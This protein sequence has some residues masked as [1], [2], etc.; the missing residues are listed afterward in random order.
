M[1]LT[2]RG[3]LVLLVSQTESDA[4]ELL[5]KVQLIFDHLPEFLKPDAWNSLRCLKFPELH[6]EIVALP[7][8]RGAG[9]GRTAHHAPSLTPSARRSKIS[10]CSHAPNVPSRS[11]SVPRA[12]GGRFTRRKR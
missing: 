2:E 4:V 11:D 5:G 7:S 1:A 8:T 12:S 6:S 3:T 9:R 10:V